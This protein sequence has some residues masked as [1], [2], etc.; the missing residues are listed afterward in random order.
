M[1]I[2]QVE[3]EAKVQGVQTSSTLLDEPV[4]GLAAAAV[5]NQER[6][7]RAAMVGCKEEYTVGDSTASTKLKREQASEAT[8]EGQRRGPVPGAV[9]GAQLQPLEAPAPPPQPSKPAV[10]RADAAKRQLLQRQ[11]P[12]GLGLAA[13]VFRA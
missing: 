7:Q 4:K 1:I 13:G 3:R 12:C 11:C 8:R 6:C 9:A 5:I 2:M 10:A